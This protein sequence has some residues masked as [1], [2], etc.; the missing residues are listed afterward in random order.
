VAKAVAG[1]GVARRALLVTL[2]AAMGEATGGRIT[3]RESGAGVMGDGM[4]EAMGAR[5]APPSS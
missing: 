1:M 5:R 4:G 2:A 3:G